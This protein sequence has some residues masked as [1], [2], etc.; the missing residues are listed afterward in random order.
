MSV[1]IE[2]TRLLSKKTSHAT[3]KKIILKKVLQSDIPLIEVK[4]LYLMFFKKQFDNP[5][6]K[7]EHKKAI[8]YLKGQD[9][10]AK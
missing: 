2:L 9:P 6:W 1:Y 4:Y 5:L 7:V 10:T 8:Q 3:W